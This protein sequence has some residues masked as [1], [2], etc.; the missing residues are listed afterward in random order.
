[1]KLLV[2]GLVLVAG[3][4]SRVT[5]EQLVYPSKPA[6]AQ[7]DQYDC[8]SFGSQESAQAE[9]ERDPSDPNDLDSDGNGRACDDYAYGT[10]NT[11]PSSVPPSSPSPSSAPPSSPSPSSASP[12]SAPP[13]SA[14][15]SPSPRPQRTRDLLD[16]GGPTLGPVPLMPNGDCPAEFPTKYQDRCR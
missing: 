5:Y 12:S 15:A 14:S 7:A 13:S 9:L 8:G 16:A 11:S 10:S 6:A 1:M 3:L 4:V 2:V